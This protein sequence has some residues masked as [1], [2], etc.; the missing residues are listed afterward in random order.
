MLAPGATASL[1]ISSFSDWLHIRRVETTVK[2]SV[3]PGLDIAQTYLHRRP[4]A[5]TKTDFHPL[6]QGGRHR[7]DT[8]ISTFSFSTSSVLMRGTKAAQAT[9]ASGRRRPII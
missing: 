8:A 6:P 9:E 7:M 4:Q 1:T 3:D 2:L 5:V